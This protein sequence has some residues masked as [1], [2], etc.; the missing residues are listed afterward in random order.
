M[1]EESIAITG[2]MLRRAGGE[3]N[4][5]ATVVVE[6]EVDGKWFIVCTEMIEANFSIIVEP[7]GMRNRIAAQEH[8]K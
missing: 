1:S 6:I 4:P 7:A 5:F 2:L 8:K 3:S